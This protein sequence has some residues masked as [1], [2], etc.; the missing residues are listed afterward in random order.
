MEEDETVV[1][2]SSTDFA[3]L[4]Y[5]KRILEDNNIPYVYNSGFCSRH[6]SHLVN[7]EIVVNRNDYIKAKKLIEENDEFFSEDAQIIDIPDELKDIDE[8]YFKEQ[9]NK[10]I[11]RKQKEN[12]ISKITI[13]GIF[14]F[15]AILLLLIAFEII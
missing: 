5:I 4:K 3:R 8:D 10:N 11:K 7:K 1:L 14:I 9:E 12:T 2:I 6:N 13:Y 15:T